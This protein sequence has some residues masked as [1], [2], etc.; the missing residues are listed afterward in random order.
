M[1]TGKIRLNAIAFNR[2]I[3]YT[4]LAQLSRYPMQLRNHLQRCITQVRIFQN[5]I[6]SPF[7]SFLVA[8]HNGSNYFL[9]SLWNGQNSNAMRCHHIVSRFVPISFRNV[10]KCDFKTNLRH[11]GSLKRRRQRILNLGFSFAF[12]FQA[13]K[14]NGTGNIS[15]ISVAAVAGGHQITTWT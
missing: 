9:A 1:M 15:C 7:F 11:T 3:L 13:E 8:A 10:F 6:A 4:L 2:A 5:F 12:Y 14:S